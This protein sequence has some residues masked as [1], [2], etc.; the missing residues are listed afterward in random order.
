MLLVAGV[1]GC[2]IHAGQSGQKTVSPSLVKLALNLQ[3]DGTVYLVSWSRGLLKEICLT[4][5]ST[6]P[7][8]LAP[9]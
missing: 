5:A 2:R 3:R 6:L 7:P 4:S 8:P 1:E 9:G